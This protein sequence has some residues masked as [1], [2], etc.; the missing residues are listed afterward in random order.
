MEKINPDK[1]RLRNFGVTM[2]IVFLV[3]FSLFFFRQKHTG[4]MYNLVVSCVFFIMGLVLPIFLKPLYLVWMRFAF[5][6]GWVNTRIILAIIFYLIFT[7]VGLA[8]RLFRIDLLETKKKK[9]TYWK[10]KEKVDFNLLNY[11][12]RF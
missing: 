9:G 5:I 6:L 8:M 7:P 12:R 1:R 4:A 11:E 2:G 3:I 10:K